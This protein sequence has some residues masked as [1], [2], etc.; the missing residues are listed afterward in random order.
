[1][2]I[3]KDCWDDW[4]CWD[5][6]SEYDFDGPNNHTMNLKDYWNK[7]GMTSHHDFYALCFDYWTK[8]F[9]IQHGIAMGVARIRPEGFWRSN[10]ILIF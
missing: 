2:F 6:F 3:E 1:M 10:R 5:N 8:L 9:L 7:H 4:Y